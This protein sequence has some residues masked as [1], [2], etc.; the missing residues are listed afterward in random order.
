MNICNVLSKGEQMFLFDVYIIP[1]LKWQIPCTHINNQNNLELNQP[2][3][4]HL[5][6]SKVI[7]CD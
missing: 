6:G 5:N 2:I 4:Y 7:T 3:F 1:L